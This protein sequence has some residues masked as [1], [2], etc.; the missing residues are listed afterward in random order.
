KGYGNAKVDGSAKD[1]CVCARPLRLG[2]CPSHLTARRPTNGRPDWW[3]NNSAWVLFEGSMLVPNL[4]VHN[5]GQE[6]QKLFPTA[7]A[8]RH[9]HPGIKY[10]RV[11]R[12]RAVAIADLIPLYK[13]KKTALFNEVFSKVGMQEQLGASLP[14]ALPNLCGII[15]NRTRRTFTERDRLVLDSL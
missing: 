4:F 3:Y 13:W 9:E 12:G 6:V 2:F 5:I 10:H 15:V 8:L 11:H 14:H 1:C 7:L